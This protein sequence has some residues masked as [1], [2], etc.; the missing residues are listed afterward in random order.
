MSTFEPGGVIPHTS[1]AP[2][3][4]LQTAVQLGERGWQLGA[5]GDREGMYWEAS[6]SHHPCS[7]G[8]TAIFS[9]VAQTGLVRV[10]LRP[11]EI[12]AQLKWRGALSV[13]LKR[14]LFYQTPLV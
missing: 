8:Y 5:Q 9:A 4:T 11:L 2:A 12:T 13:L 14:N 1:A 7:S 10:C 3:I 6:Q